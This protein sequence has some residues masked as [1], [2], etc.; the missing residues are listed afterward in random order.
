MKEDRTL[1]GEIGVPGNKRIAAYQLVDALERLG[2]EYIFGLCGHT[3]IAVLDALRSSSIH[4][5]TARHEQVAAHMA[6]GYARAT[7]KPG[8]VLL[9]LGPGLTNAMTGIANA[10]LDSIPLVIIAG[11]IPSYYHG[12][13]AHQEVNQHAEATQ[14]EMLR[15][16]AKWSWRVERPESLPR[17]LK[18]AF[19]IAQTGRRGPVFI[20]VPMDFFSAVLPADAFAFPPP[21][22]IP[23]IPLPAATAREIAAL[24][25]EAERPVMYVGGGTTSPGASRAL[26]ALAEWLSIPVAYSLMGKTAI[27]DTHPLC[28]GMT[29]FW[30]TPTA[31]NLCREADII[32]AVGTRFAE[33]DSSSWDPRFTFQIPPTKLIHIDIDSYEIGRNYPATIAATADAR[34]ALEA[35][36]EAV[37]EREQQPRTLTQRAQ[38]AAS[39]RAEFLAD[40]AKQATSDAFPL[41]PQRILTDVRTV[42]P[43][44]ALIATDVGWN[45]N[46]VGQQFLVTV[47]GTL[48]TP[49]GYATMGFGPAAVIGAKLGAPERICVALIGDG[50]M[51][52]QLSALITAVEYKVPVVWLV[53]NNYAFGTIAGLETQHYGSGFGCEFIRD[54]QP[55]NPDFAALARA[56]G[57]K[58]MKVEVAADLLPALREA[59]ASGQP[60]L[61][62]VPMRNDPVPTTGHWDINDIYCAGA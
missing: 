51:G 62:D 37:R 45:K 25:L 11:D 8:V 7:G 52:S 3:N 34:L 43:E 50:A 47:P 39:E 2:V 14:W 42:L 41:Y 26:V 18:R 23:P 21:V 1:T 44:D 60:T 5:V 20:D 46:G 12:R 27:P 29:G 10:A 53:M 36:L 49:G 16:L 32:L 57:A 4:W 15:P 13:H 33:A 38:Q 59:V 28:L 56:C 40:A 9:H 58:G 54:G 19:H 22:P 24:L 17:I 31:N 6:D 35:I 30:G 55:Y 61:L 48:L